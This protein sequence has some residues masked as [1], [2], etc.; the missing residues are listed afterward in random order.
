MLFVVV[1]GGKGGCCVSTGP[2]EAGGGGLERARQRC[3]LAGDLV[4]AQGRTETKVGWLFSV[5]TGSSER[6]CRCGA[7][8]FVCLQENSFGKHSTFSCAYD[9]ISDT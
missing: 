1:V 7:S 2:D 3:D 5:F 8:V 6:P 4:Y 9:F